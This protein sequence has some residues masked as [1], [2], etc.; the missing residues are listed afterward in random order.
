MNNAAATELVKQ[1]PGVEFVSCDVAKHG[2][3]YELFKSAHDRYGRVDH[4]ISCAGIFEQGNWYDPALTI[5][6]VKSNTGNTKVMDVNVLGTLQ[7]AR[8]AAVFM[9]DGMEKADNKSL[10]LLSS[11]NAFRESPGLFL[12]QVRTPSHSAT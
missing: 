11:V 8:I 5:E 9:R 10:T 7:F 4:A 12:Y 3:I 2:D 1:H 6:S